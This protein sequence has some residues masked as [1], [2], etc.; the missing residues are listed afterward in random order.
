MGMVMGKSFSPRQIRTGSRIRKLITWIAAKESLPNGSRPIRPATKVVAILKWG[1][2]KTLYRLASVPVDPV[3]MSIV[4]PDTGLV[5]RC[6]QAKMSISELV[7]CAVVAYYL[8]EVRDK[9]GET[10]YLDRWCSEIMSAS[11]LGRYSLR[12]EESVGDKED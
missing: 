1:E 10:W 5:A 6:T 8:R 12:V 7:R 3:F 9:Q 11:P 2:S 4:L